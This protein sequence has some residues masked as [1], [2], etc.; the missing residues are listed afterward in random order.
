MEQLH[1][2]ISTTEDL[3]IGVQTV[4]DMVSSHNMFTVSV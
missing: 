3:D 1:P 2:L 4:L